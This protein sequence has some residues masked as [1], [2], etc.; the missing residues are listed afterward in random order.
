M[1]QRRQPVPDLLLSERLE[2]ATEKKGMDLWKQLSSKWSFTFF[3]GIFW[4]KPVPS[5]DYSLCSVCI[6]HQACVLLSVC[7]LQFTL[8]L[9]FTPGPQ[10]AVCV[11][12]WQRIKYFACDTQ[13]WNVSVQTW[14]ILGISL[15]SARTTSSW[16][17][18]LTH[19][20]LLQNKVCKNL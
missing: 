15:A 8:D 10:F 14:N 16:V 19:N 4:L 20:N 5:R 13:L 11:L 3:C 1:F 18:D 12:H 7:R 6:L 9:H 17:T 2:Q